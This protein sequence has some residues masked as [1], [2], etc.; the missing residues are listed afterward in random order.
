MR[1][2][3]LLYAIS[4]IAQAQSLG[5]SPT[6]R[7][8]AIDVYTTFR[9]PRANE[10]ALTEK[11]APFG[12]VKRSQ[13]LGVA[14]STATE[15]WR[16]AQAQFANLDAIEPVW[17]SHSA[18]F[19]GTKASALNRLLDRTLVVRVSAATLDVDEPI[20]ITHSG[21]FL[22]LEGV[23]LSAVVPL[24]YML[25]IENA[26]NVVLTGGEFMRGESAILVNRS[27]QVV[28]SDVHIRDLTEAGVVITHSSNVVVRDNKMH[29]LGG[30]AVILHGGTSSSVAERNEIAANRGVSNMS[31]AIV[32][33]DRDVDLTMR[34]SVLEGPDHY[35]VVSQPMIKRLQPPHNNLIVMNHLAANNSSA[36]YID[37]A[38][39]NVIAL[40]VIEGNAKEG[41]CLDNGA[42][43]NVVTLN[44]VLQNGGRSGE[45]DSIMEKESIKAGG[46]LPDGTPAEKVPGISID[47]AIYNIIFSNNVAHNFGGGI[48]IVRTGYFNVIGL[49]TILSNNEGAGDIYHFFG[50]EL[51]SAP[52]DFPDETLDYTPSR[53]NIVFSNTIRGSHYAGI[54]FA[55][56]SDLNDVFDNVI[57][58]AQHWALESVL[59][60]ANSSL[61][62]LTNLESRNIDSG[63][64][65]ALIE[66]GRPH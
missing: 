37:G 4:Q 11:I 46:R 17:P 36:V 2:S 5:V 64:S 31:A 30:A 59:P 44:D 21:T 35:W 28:V 49:N 38:T 24:P 20:R 48:K 19:T 62:N 54:F 13:A 43:A 52:L 9:L 41:I 23:R 53:G 51:G 42:T 22:S 1:I 7:L 27:H 16:D 61:N 39:A 10:G 50:I 66:A 6:A 14:F 34:A 55:A 57:M 45:P 63:L 47:N 40:N 18:D 3:L 32:V 33:S 60:M 58:D 25:R 12:V 26:G 15:A 65:P 29:G 8:G 56:G